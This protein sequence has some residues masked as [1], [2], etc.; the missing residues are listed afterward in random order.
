LGV[1]FVTQFIRWEGGEVVFSYIHSVSLLVHSKHTK[2][3]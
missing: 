3:T 2:K 1:D